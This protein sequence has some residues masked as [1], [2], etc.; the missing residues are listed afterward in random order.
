MFYTCI[1]F[2]QINVNQFIFDSNLSIIRTTV[3]ETLQRL[4]F[5]KP[6]LSQRG[7][8]GPEKIMHVE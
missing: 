4:T 6:K 1:H 2:A 7:M 5:G 8:F 3:S